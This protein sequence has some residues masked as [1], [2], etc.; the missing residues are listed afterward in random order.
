MEYNTIKMENTEQVEEAVKTD[1]IPVADFIAKYK[2][3]NSDKARDLYLKSIVKDE[4]VP[5]LVKQ[6]WARQIIEGA[7]FNEEGQVHFDGIKQ[8]LS[9]VYTL[10]SLYTKLDVQGVG[11]NAQFDV[12]D[13]AGVIKNLESIMP[14]DFKEFQVMYKIVEDDFRENYA[15]TRINIEDISTQVEIGVLNGVNKVLSL[16]SEA[17]QDENVVAQLQQLAN[18]S[19]QSLEEVK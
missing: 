7:S 15:I 2:G 9:Y 4:Y 8:Y 19:G 17:L 18:Q 11:F 6:F 10:L 13:E 3:M 5:Y 16:I 12:L 1:L 14:K